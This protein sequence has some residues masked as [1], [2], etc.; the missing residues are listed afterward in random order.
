MGNGEKM[1]DL[2][3]VPTWAIVAT[4][5]EPWPL[6]IAFTL[7]HLGIG[8]REVHLYF[9]RPCPKAEA[10]LAGLDRVHITRCT[11]EYWAASETGIRPDHVNR[12]QRTNANAAFAKCNADWILHADADEYLRPGGLVEA[13]LADLPP[14][15]IAVRQLVMERAFLAE[16]PPAHI[17]DGVFRTK[18]HQFHLWREEV[19]GRFGKFMKRGFSGHDAGKTF[20][21]VGTPDVRFGIHFAFDKEDNIVEN[22]LREPDA[23]MHFDGMTE[24]HYTFKMMRR[25]GLPYYFSAGNPD[26]PARD[27][28]ARYLRN[29]AEKPREVA[30]LF[31]GI[32][33]LDAAQRAALSGRDCLIEQRFDP[34]PYIAASG[35]E[36]DL[37]PEHFDAA[38]IEWAADVPELEGARS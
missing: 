36:L 11:P 3:R 21:R 37:S 26:G 2:P 7:Y 14:H 19:Y 12:R 22:S 35:I 38:L 1:T 33:V 15:I 16:T 28:Q 20:L 23:L 10:L 34:R 30:R 6:V 32:M 5:D 13:S 24:L 9:D 17:F 25:L 8:A 4:I 29:N 31:S 18:A 27:S